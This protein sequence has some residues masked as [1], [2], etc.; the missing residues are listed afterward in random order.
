LYMLGTEPEFLVSQARSAVTAAIT[1]FR[2]LK[3]I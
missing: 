2:F 1:P 3:S